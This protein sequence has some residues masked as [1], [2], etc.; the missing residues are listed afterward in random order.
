MIGHFDSALF[1]V[2]WKML[3]DSW[4]EVRSSILVLR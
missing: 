3:L 1:D 4:L 2:S